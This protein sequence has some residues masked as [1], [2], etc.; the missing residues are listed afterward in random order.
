MA[1]F[2]ST[3][4]IST[5]TY[6]YDVPVYSPVVA[7]ARLVAAAERVTALK[8]SVY[9][10]N[11]L[12]IGEDSAELSTAL[13]HK[14]AVAD[15]LPTAQYALRFGNSKLL[16][17]N[18]SATTA[19]LEA[20]CKIPGKVE[21]FG[22]TTDL[23]KLTQALQSLTGPDGPPPGLYPGLH[24][25]RAD[26]TAT[27]MQ[28]P[29]LAT[30]LVQPRESQTPGTVLAEQQLQDLE[31]VSGVDELATVV[32]AIADSQTSDFFTEIADLSE[33]LT[34]VSYVGMLPVQTGAAFLVE[35]NTPGSSPAALLAAITTATSELPASLHLTRGNASH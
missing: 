25:L 19:V 33:Y 8:S 11:E 6:G 31:K 2:P 3:K 22:R 5:T 23:A 32:S 7:D 21:A 35:H 4:Y 28:V 29:R 34:D 18:P 30:V 12:V 10:S 16:P 26:G 13:R 1:F 9:Q 17:T 14:D 24:I 15:F 27:E 20:L